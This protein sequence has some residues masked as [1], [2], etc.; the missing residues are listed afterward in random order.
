MLARTR[1]N[2]LLAP[3]LLCRLLRCLLGLCLGCPPLG[4]GLLCGASGGQ[5]KR[6]SACVQDSRAPVMQH[7]IMKSTDGARV[8]ECTEFLRCPRPAAVRM[9]PPVT[10][11]LASTLER[12]SS[13]ISSTE[14]FCGERSNLWGTKGG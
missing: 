12:S 3:L 11:V 2:A 9:R 7:I 13:I 14:G 1:Q 10:G 6:R 4:K 5:R 8:L